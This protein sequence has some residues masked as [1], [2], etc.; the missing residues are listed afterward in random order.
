MITIH[1]ADVT[2]ARQICYVDTGVHYLYARM[3]NLSYHNGANLRFYNG[4][5]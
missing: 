2:T 4:A 3:A 5:N 1:F